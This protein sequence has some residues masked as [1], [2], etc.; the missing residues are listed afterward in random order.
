MYVKE[1]SRRSWHGD[2]PR[3]F[4]K[5]KRWVVLS[6]QMREGEADRYSEVGEWIP[7]DEFT[8]RLTQTLRFLSDQGRTN[9]ANT[10]AEHREFL[11]SLR[12]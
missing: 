8:N 1:P 3:W 11:P 6:P 4:R 9:W 5:E 2:T 10:V 12:K 7:T